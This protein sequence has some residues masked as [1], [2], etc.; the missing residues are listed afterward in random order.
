[1]SEV[2]RCFRQGFEVCRTIGGVSQFTHEMQTNPPGVVS[3]EALREA[4][5][6]VVDRTRERVQAVSCF[7][8]PLSRALVQD[9]RTLR[10]LLQQE[11]YLAATKL[12]RGITNRISELKP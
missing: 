2:L 1:M 7:T 5:I 12:T 4:W 6:L 8:E 10:D 11:D 3:Q 9:L